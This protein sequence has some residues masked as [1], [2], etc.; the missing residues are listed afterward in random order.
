MNDQTTREQCMG[1]EISTREIL[2]GIFVLLGAVI[3]AILVLCL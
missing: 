3:M 1:D 2:G